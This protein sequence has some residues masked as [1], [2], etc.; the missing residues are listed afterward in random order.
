MA[1][2]VYA[3][4]DTGKGMV[5]DRHLRAGEADTR[6]PN[7]DER[8]HAMGYVPLSSLAGSAM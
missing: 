1:T 4:R 3:F 8:E 7:P 6:E 5:Y 2:Q